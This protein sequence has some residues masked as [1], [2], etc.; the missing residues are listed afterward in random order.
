M[1]MITQLHEL[2][3][4]MDEDSLAS[5]RQSVSS[6]LASRKRKTVFR[7]EDIHPGMTEDEKGKV[8][9]QIARV[10]KGED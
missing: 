7:V 8:A 2:V 6:E 3:R 5:L 10:L 1:D 9:D 4:D